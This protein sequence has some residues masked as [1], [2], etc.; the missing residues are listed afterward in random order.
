MLAHR[1]E[2]R[3]HLATDSALHRSKDL[4]VSFL[5][6]GRPIPETGI[7]IL[8]ESDVSVRTSRLAADGD[9]PLPFCALGRR[10][11]DFPPP[12]TLHPTSAMQCRTDYLLR[13]VSTYT[14]IRYKVVGGDRLAWSGN[15]VPRIQVRRQLGI[16]HYDTKIALNRDSCRL[17]RRRAI[18]IRIIGR[19]LLAC[20]DSWN[21]YQ[22]RRRGRDSRSIAPRS[23]HSRRR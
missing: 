23:T 22:H 3:F 6:R 13:N 16:P 1:L 8:S 7:P 4:A 19:A 9:Y 17:P 12:T 10:C 5:P 15:I 14:A 2:R 21:T 20:H 18:L 11:S